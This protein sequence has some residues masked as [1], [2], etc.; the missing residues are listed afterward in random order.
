MLFGIEKSRGIPGAAWDDS[1]LESSGDV[2]PETGGSLLTAE[3]DM[4]AGMFP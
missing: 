1:E 4:H 3:G 2:G